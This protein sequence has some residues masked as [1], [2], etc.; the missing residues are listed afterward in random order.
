VIIVCGCVPPMKPIYRHLLTS[1]ASR[2]A[3]G[4]MSAS[5]SRVRSRPV[6][7]RQITVKSFAQSASHAV[8]SDEELVSPRQIKATTSVQMTSEPAPPQASSNEEVEF[9]TFVKSQK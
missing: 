8:D 9:S 7:S 6:Y 4:E 1:E 3:Y 2:A 5:G